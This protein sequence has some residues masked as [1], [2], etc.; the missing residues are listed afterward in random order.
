MAP[1]AADANFAALLIRPTAGSV[2]LLTAES[3]SR[4]SQFKRA[5]T[6]SVNQV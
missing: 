3:G 6:A 5:E 2:E 1:M 4:M